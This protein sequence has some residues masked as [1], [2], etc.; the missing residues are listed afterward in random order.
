MSLVVRRAAISVAAL[1]VWLVFGILVV[2]AMISSAHA[3]TGI[4][5]LNAMIAGHGDHPLSEYL[6]YWRNV[7]LLG[8]LWCAGWWA[9]GPLTRAVMSPWFFDR[10]VG[11]ATPGTLGA[12]RAWT[13][14]ILLVMTVWED[15]P[16]TTLLPRDMAQPKGVLYV[17]HVLPIG[18]ESFLASWTALRAF[19]LLT[20]ALL[21]LGVVGLGSRIV[22]P[23]A[24]AC[25]LVVAG[26][27]REY[28]WFY[29][30][31]LIPLYV[32]TALSFTPSGD[33]WSIDRLLRVARGRA[34]P[35][36]EPQAVYGWSRY[37][38]WTVLAVP[39]VAAALSKLYYSGIA[40]FHP[41]NMLA[42][43]LRTTLAPME[44]DWQLSLLLVE[45][46]GVLLIG[47]AVVGLF[48]ELLFGLVLVSPVARR[49]VPLAMAATHVG[50]LF[51]QNILFIDLILLQA[52]FYDFGIARRVVARW[53]GRRRGVVEVLY[54]G[55]CG[56]C[57][58]AVRVLRGLDLFE[59][60]AFIDF[61]SADLAGYAARTR[62]ALDPASLEH[63]MAVVHPSGRLYQGFSAYRA[64]AWHLPM[65][66]LMLP[67]LYL[68]GVRVM[69]DAVYRHVAERRSRRCD[70]VRDPVTTPLAGVS[71]HRRGA[72]AAVGLALFLMS[73][74]VTHI[75]FYP[76]T[77]LKMF[78]ALNEPLGT[79][80]YV[81]PLAVY[82]DGRREQ[83]RFERWIGAMA[84]S[85]YR[86]TLTAAFR[87]DARSRRTDEFLGASL[88][89]AN[90]RA[91]AGSRVV[92]FELQLWEWDFANEPRSPTRGR[93][94]DHYV[95]PA[96]ASWPAAPAN[97]AHRD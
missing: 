83:A 43:L 68:P 21:A 87:D 19:E 46:P 48:S 39:Y 35:S 45:A 74:W 20:V 56:M 65:G 49:I 59:R 16:S 15:L 37:L 92:G 85:R 23:A 32:L 7:T 12:I 73:W 76:F 71:V 64:M 93:M 52:V 18:F 2:P 61:R 34:V 24:A 86:Q 78:S 33:G 11:A 4:P 62:P 10:A 5:L 14:G 1:A 31:G 22:V 91:A 42:T 60:C 53:L 88:R 28:S 36:A 30:T 40:W 50:I 3:G 27:F 79:I 77:T 67:V 81:M 51:L 94:I 38:I 63:A 95:Y 55:R 66:W 25:Y 96:D 72:V 54:D 26:V 89:E 9:V 80:A 29:H 69:G 75:E 97:H 47:L 6:E 57:G 8:A 82:E 13:C 70:I 41:D 90:R 58:R 44:F 84:D 17:L